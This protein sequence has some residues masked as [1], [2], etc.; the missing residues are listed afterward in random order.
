MKAIDTSALILVML[1]SF[2]IGGA[3][4]YE[5]GKK[6]ICQDQFQGEIHKGKCVKVQREEVK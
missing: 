2:I 1:T 5:I 3:M 6:A 4:G